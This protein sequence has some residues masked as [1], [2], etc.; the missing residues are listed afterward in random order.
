M[1]VEFSF[2]VSTLQA[3]LTGASGMRVEMDHMSST[4][5]VSLRKFFW[6]RGGDFGA[7]EDGLDSDPTVRE[8]KRVIETDDSRYYRVIYQDDLPGVEAYHAVVE[9]DGMVLDARTEGDGWNGRIRFPDRGALNEW[10]DRCEAVGLTVDV[11]AIYDQERHPPDNSYGLT[12]G[13]REALVTAAECGYF[14]IPR[15]TSLSGVGDELGVSSQS[16]SERLRRGM[17]TLIENTL[18]ER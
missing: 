7:F 5:T 18:E 15:E 16:A 13:Q 9:L 3:A 8:P 2:D 11:H 4:D 6:A 14:S 1:I 10:C 12:S 17:V